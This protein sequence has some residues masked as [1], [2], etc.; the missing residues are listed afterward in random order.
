MLG[1]AVA[2]PNLQFVTMAQQRVQPQDK[3]KAMPC[4]YYLSEFAIT[5]AATLPVF[6]YIEH[7]FKLHIRHSLTQQPQMSMRI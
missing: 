7:H 5:F 4:P 1:F 3:G 2:Q 6:H